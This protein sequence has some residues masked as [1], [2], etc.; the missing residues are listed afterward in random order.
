MRIHD[1]TYHGSRYPWSFDQ[2]TL[3]AY[4]RY[5]RLKVRLIPLVQ[6]WSAWAAHSG[7]VGPV[8]PLVLD[9]PSPA[10]R[11][12]DDEWLLGADV[13]AA[14]VLVEGAVS[15]RVYLP[16]GARWQPVRVGENGDWVPSGAPLAGGQTVT[17]PAPY[18]D[19]PIFLRVVHPRVRL[20]C[21]RRGVK[22]TVYGRDLRG[23]IRIRVDRRHGH[24]LAVLITLEDARTLRLSARLPRCA[25]PPLPPAR[26]RA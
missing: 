26:S 5:A 3:D 1:D 18:D 13:L 17:A 7:T 19:I 21:T 14:P 24:R 10:A 4:R 6:R 2:R 15:R 23:V 11:A 9:D 20:A 8:R 12:I 25:T 22:V 16:A